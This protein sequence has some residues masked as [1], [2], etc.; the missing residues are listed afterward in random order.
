MTERDREEGREKGR[1]SEGERGGNEWEKLPIG[2]KLYKK[3]ICRNLNHHE[4]F[5]SFRFHTANKDEPQSL[6]QLWV[7]GFKFGIKVQT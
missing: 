5:D 1:E 3:S 6:N 4:L 7:F 2:K